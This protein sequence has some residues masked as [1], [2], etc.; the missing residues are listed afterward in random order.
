[1]IGHSGKNLEDS[2]TKSN[3]DYE[4]CIETKEE[5]S[6]RNNIRNLARD[7]FCDI[8]TK[9][10]AAFCHCVKFSDVKLKSIRLISLAEEILR[11]SNTDSLVW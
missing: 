5:V 7:D 10:V 6:E 1:M 2:R 3:T 9:N 8:L 4:G 11:Q